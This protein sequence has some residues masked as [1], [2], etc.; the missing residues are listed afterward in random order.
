MTS[1]T[2]SRIWWSETP[3]ACEVCGVT[4]GAIRASLVRTTDPVHPFASLR[5]CSDA[6]ACRRRREAGG[7]P[8]WP[9]IEARPPRDAR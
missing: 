8:D 6:V 4:R 1:A 9:I 5:R 2:A 3:A 7:H